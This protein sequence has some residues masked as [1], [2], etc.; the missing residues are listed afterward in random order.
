A[1]SEDLAPTRGAAVQACPR[2]DGRWTI[3]VASSG[4][5]GHAEVAIMDA[6]QTEVGAE[7]ALWWGARPTPE[8]PRPTGRVI[9]RGQLVPGEVRSV[10]VPLRAGA[11]VRVDVT[12]EPSLGAIRLASSSGEAATGRGLRVCRA[13]AGPAPRV[14]VSARGPG[15]YRL[16]IVGSDTD[17]D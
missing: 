7:T 16:F 3:E 12:G 8:R 6:Q 17:S 4:G 14:R 1:R 2:R 5:R 15:A 11:C 9:L 13:R 10:S